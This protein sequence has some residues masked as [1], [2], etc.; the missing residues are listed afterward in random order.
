MSEANDSIWKLYC[1]FFIHLNFWIA[2]TS[3]SMERHKQPRY[4]DAKF[5]VLQASYRRKYFITQGSSTKTPDVVLQHK[6]FAPNVAESRG[7]TYVYKLY[8]NAQ[9][10]KFATDLLTPVTR[11]WIQRA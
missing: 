2:S 5:T 11:R 4:I 10:L 8:V 7:N 9:H 1:F 6:Q 3:T